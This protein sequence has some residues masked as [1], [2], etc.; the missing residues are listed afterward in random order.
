MNEE[1]RLILKNQREIMEFLL[2]PKNPD[3][4]FKQ[5]SLTDEALAPKEDDGLAEQRDKDLE[6]KKKGYGG[7]YRFPSLPANKE[8]DK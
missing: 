7:S 6:D 1:T 3:G 8:K 2:Y 5:R 4:L